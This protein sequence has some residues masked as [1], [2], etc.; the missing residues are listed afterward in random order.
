M[1]TLLILV[2]MFLV[3]S[4]LLIGLALALAFVLSKLLPS[5]A[6]GMCVIA[7][8]VLAVGVL[9][10]LVR[11]LVAFNKFDPDSGDDVEIEDPVIVVPG[12]FLSRSI[13]RGTKRKKKNT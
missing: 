4:G 5:V 9:D 13:R 12:S 8:S 11:F 2:V 1:A 6:F 3:C 10:F 7:G